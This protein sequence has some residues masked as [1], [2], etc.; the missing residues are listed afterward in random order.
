MSQ[1]HSFDNK[2]GGG[3]GQF[4]IF[5]DKVGRGVWTHQFLAD[6]ISEQFLTM[7]CTALSLQR[8]VMHY[9]LHSAL[10]ICE[11]FLTMYF[12]LLLLQRALHIALNRAEK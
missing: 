9:A 8:A 3:L 10:N 4:L 5:A 12:T 2:A 7:P 11:Q 6:I 1:F